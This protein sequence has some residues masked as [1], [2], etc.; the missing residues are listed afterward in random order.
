PPERALRAA[1]RNA[2]RFESSSHSLDDIQAILLTVGNAFEQGANQIRARVL[3]GHANPAA[4]RQC[5]EMRSALAHQ[6]RQPE[7]SLRTGWSLR[8]LRC[9]RVVIRAR[10]ELVAEPLEAKARS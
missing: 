2:H 7:Q 10:R 4:A 5:V 8:R 9:Q 3:R 6:I 1:A